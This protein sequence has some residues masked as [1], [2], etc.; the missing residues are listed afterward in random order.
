MTRA[1]PRR[2]GAL[3]VALVLGAAIAPASAAFADTPQEPY[4]GANLATQSITIGTNESTAGKTSALNVSGCCTG[5]QMPDRVTVKVDASGA[6]GVLVVAVSG[7]T[8]TVSGPVTTCDV[9]LPH[10]FQ[11]DGALQVNLKVAAGA[12]VGDE[13]T[14]KLDV[15]GTGLHSTSTDATVE[16]VASAADLV[17]R[18]FRADITKPGDTRE[19]KPEFRNSGDVT[20]KW[21]TLTIN[22]AG[23]SRFGKRFSN[24]R[25]TDFDGGA[26]GAC[27]FEVD[28]APGETAQFATA[29]PVVVQPDVPN[30]GVAYAYYTLYVYDSTPPDASGTPGNG[31]A[32][33]PPVKVAGRPIPGGEVENAFRG[34]TVA[35][36]VGDNPADLSAIGAEAT[37]AAGSSLS[38]V[39]GLKNG[40]PAVVPGNLD[41]EGLSPDA[42]NQ[43]AATVTFPAGATVLSVP[44]GLAPPGTDAPKD[45]YVFCAPIVNGKADW[46]KLGKVVGL[47]YRCTANNSPGSGEIEPIRFTVSIS[48]TATLT[49]TIVVSGGGNDPNPANNTASIK[50]IP[51][52]AGGNGGITALPVTG[53]PTGIIALGGSVLLLLGLG[54]VLLTRRGRAKSGA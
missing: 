40:G 48:G 43:P 37:G 50:L 4:A 32:L 34:G 15:S 9:P 33:A 12:K 31:P 17:G 54:L 23:F 5:Q 29:I 45:N 47:V 19:F 22:A 35:I 46:T 16:V 6:A 1:L 21:V 3:A 20:A 44:D 28:L 41:G 39:L 7:G 24:C 2:L 25:Y 49:G 14:L 10:E 51:A 52:G 30:H 18:S 53:R 8:C 26:N 27:A 11:P 38:L 36:P 42:P 13:A